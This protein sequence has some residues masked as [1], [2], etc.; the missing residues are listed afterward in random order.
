MSVCIIK[1][2]CPVD[3]P[4]LEFPATELDGSMADIHAASE[5]ASGATTEAFCF[6]WSQAA[7]FEVSYD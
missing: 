5:V 1:A 2:D 3:N 6:A 7:R 4:F